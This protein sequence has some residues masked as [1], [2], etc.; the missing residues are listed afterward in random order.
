MIRI[1]AFG[2]VCYT[3]LM[4]L[5]LHFSMWTSL[6]P[7]PHPLIPH[8]DTLAAVILNVVP[9]HIYKRVGKLIQ[10]ASAQQLTPASITDATSQGSVTYRD[11]HQQRLSKALCGAASFSFSLF[12]SLPPSPLICLPATQ[13]N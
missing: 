13:C 8:Q 6:S 12:L 1:T 2:G 4:D 7:L 3:E 9:S 5:P 10:G 11:V